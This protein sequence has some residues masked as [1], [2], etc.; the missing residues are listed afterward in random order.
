MAALIIVGWL[1]VLA[2][3]FYRHEKRPPT[4]GGL[5]YFVWSLTVDLTPGAPLAGG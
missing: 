1:V 2:L 3:A 5:S 4:E